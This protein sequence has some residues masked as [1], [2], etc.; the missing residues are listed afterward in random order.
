MNRCPV[1]IVPDEFDFVE[2]K[3]IAFPTGFNRFYDEEILPLKR[4]SELYDSKIRILH[5]NEEEKLT[6]LQ[7]YNYTMLKMYLKNHECSFHWMPDY[8]KKTQEI[9][10]F[11]EELNINILVMINYKHSFIESIVKEPII[12]KIGFH[13]SIPFL[14]IPCVI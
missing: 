2:P 7:D 10:D 1:L 13:P 3:Q 9:N 11:I 14:V 8:A 4:L 5:I 6:H 12:K